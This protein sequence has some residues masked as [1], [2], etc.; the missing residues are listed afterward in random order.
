MNAE[1]RRS[2]P[3]LRAQLAIL[4]A[5][6]GE[7][8]TRRRRQPAL[9]LVGLGLVVRRTH[10]R[11]AVSVRSRSGATAS[12]HWSG[13]GG[14]SRIGVGSRSASFHPSF[15]QWSRQPERAD[16]AFF[17]RDVFLTGAAPSSA[18]KVRF[19]AKARDSVKLTTRQDTVLLGVRVAPGSDK[20]KAPE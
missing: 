10:S 4:L 16:H 17:D 1:P 5:R 11:K 18:A 15:P 9:C 13:S 12:D 6:P 20:G 19:G 14:R 8:L 3:L 7:L 2:A